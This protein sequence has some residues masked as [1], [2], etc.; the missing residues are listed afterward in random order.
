MTDMD[1]YYG[2]SDVSTYR[3]Y[4]TPLTGLT[5]IPES[6]FSGRSNT[7]LSAS[8]SV[9]V[10]GTAFASAYTEGDNRLVVATDT[11]K[12]FIHRE[13][14]VFTGATLEE[15]LEFIGRRFLETY[16]LMERLR[17]SGTEIPFEPALVPGT[18]GGF[19]ESEVLFERQHGDRSTASLDLDRTD[20]GVEV[21]DLSAGRIGLQMMKV[22][23]SAFADFARDA[24]TT[25]PE[26]K[27]RPLYIHLDLGWKYDSPASALATDHSKYVA[28]EQ[29][30][31]M[32]GAV[33][34]RFV[35][36]S[37]QHLIHEIGQAMLDR[38]PQLSEISFDGQNRL[39]DLSETSTTDE[40]VKVYTDPRPPYGQLGLVLRR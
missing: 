13:S 15:W 11:M 34:H 3:T 35:S 14:L 39:W 19:V 22:T 32:V 26:R 4:A 23:G 37:I 6:S 21:T 30:A 29:V 1:I 10:L 9:R 20:A 40:R 24:Y 33:F 18:D 8:I 17:I 2:K 36:L 28:G 38:W 27:D 16:P 31:D 12:N 25:L 5:Q 7:L